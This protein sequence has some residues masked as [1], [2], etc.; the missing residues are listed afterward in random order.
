MDI[1]TRMT[2]SVHIIEHFG[3]SQI[4]LIVLP[5]AL[6]AIGLQEVKSADRA[7]LHSRERQGATWHLIFGAK[8]C[9]VPSGMIN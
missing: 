2:E 6:L 8:G 9:L 4:K 5:V 7:V 1:L 3:L